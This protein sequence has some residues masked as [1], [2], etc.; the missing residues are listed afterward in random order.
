MLYDV[1]FNGAMRLKVVNVEADSMAAAA[2][3][4]HRYA[5]DNHRD[6]EV[7][8]GWPPRRDQRTRIAYAE[9]CEELPAYAMVDRVG[10]DDFVETRWLRAAESGDGYVLAERQAPEPA[11]ERR[12]MLVL[13]TAH[14]SA[15]TRAGL[16][17]SSGVDYPVLAAFP[18]GWYVHVAPA[19]CGVDEHTLPIDLRAAIAFARSLGCDEIKFDCDADV[20]EGLPVYAEA[21]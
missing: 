7:C 20:A 2:M 6:A 13:S 14:L 18:Y 1:C 21:P 17:S 12:S 8:S 3:K 5:Q 9:V 11:H 19:D 10:D 4:A 15:Q 16:A